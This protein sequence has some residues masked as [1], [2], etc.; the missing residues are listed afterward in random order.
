MD[1]KIYSDAA[2]TWSFGEEKVLRAIDY[3]YSGQI[4]F[5]NIMGGLFSDYRDLLPINMKD[6]DSTEMANK[7]LFEMWK[8]G[9][10]F[11]KMPM[12]EN[13]PNLLSQEKS[14]V[15]PIDIGFVAARLTD[16]DL[17][18][19]Y[20]RAL[21]EATILDARDTMSADVQIEIAKEVG[22]N[23]DEYKKNLFNFANEEFLEDRM[24]SFDHRFT[25]FPNFIYKN[26]DGREVLIKGYKKLS[27]LIE[28]IDDNAEEKLEKKEILTNNEIVLDFINKYE[29][30]FKIELYELFDKEKIDEILSNLEK[31]NKIKISTVGTG[32]EIKIVK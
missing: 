18:N 31:E 6:Q 20:L 14:S 21:R 22:F 2:C 15:Y 8:T 32:I 19:K 7:I 9:S 24:S 5:I 29:R 10:N 4:R 25:L 28:F 12:M 23:E 26:K 11:H 27:E 1:I 3:I 13:P 17:A 16:K 30:V